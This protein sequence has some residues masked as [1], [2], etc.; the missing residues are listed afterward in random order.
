MVRHRVEAS[1]TL[2]GLLIIALVTGNTFLVL[3][4]VVKILTG[5]E[6]LRSWQLRVFNAPRS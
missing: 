3:V 6:L 1:V 2:V 5:D 4:E